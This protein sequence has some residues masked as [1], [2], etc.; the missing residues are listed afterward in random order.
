[1]YKTEGYIFYIKTL[2]Y[3]HGFQRMGRNPKLDRLKILLGRL[4]FFCGHPQEWSMQDT[5]VENDP[6]N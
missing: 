2:V 5:T 4:F 1:M 3:I 6:A